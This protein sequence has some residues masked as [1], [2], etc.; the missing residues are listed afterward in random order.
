MPTRLMI[1]LAI[2][3]LT[4]AACSGKGVDPNALVTAAPT[5]VPTATTTTITAR[6]QGALLYNQPIELHANS[7]TDA[8]PQAGTLI[9]TVNTDPN[10]LPTGGQARFSA[11][12][13]IATYCWVYHYTTPAPVQNVTAQVCT[14]NWASGFTL[15]S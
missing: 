5:A 3:A 10:T 6:Y 2:A 9:A 14:S 12:N 13:P 8:A 11:L 7:G 15:G 4:L 1:S